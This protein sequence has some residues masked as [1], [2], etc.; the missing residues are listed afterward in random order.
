MSALMRVKKFYIVRFLILRQVSTHRVD[1][2]E[3]MGGIFPHAE[4]VEACGPRLDAA[5]NSF[6]RAFAGMTIIGV[7]PTHWALRASAI[8]EQSG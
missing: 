3:E 5:T 7:G 4:P 2:D 6:I 8:I 1:E